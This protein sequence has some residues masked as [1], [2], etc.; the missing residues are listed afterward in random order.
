MPMTRRGL[1]YPPPWLYT[2][3]ATHK[4]NAENE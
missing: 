3:K 4:L 2:A 1:I